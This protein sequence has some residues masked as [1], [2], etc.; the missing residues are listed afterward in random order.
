MIMSSNVVFVVSILIAVL[1]RGSSKTDKG[2]KGE[3]GKRKRWPTMTAASFRMIAQ[4]L[5]FLIKMDP[6][7][8]KNA[9]AS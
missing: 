4:L 2:N 6:P 9:S 3:I 7:P 1:K 5:I 8:D